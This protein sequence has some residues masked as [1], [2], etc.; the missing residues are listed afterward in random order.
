MSQRSYE[1]SK[2]YLKTIKLHKN[3]N[4]KAARPIYYVVLKPNSF[5]LDNTFDIEINFI[6]F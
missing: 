6:V 2:Y 1:I 4:L 3:L 5:E